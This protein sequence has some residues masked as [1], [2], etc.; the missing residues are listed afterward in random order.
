MV[1]TKETNGRLLGGVH[2]GD[3]L[4][5]GSCGFERVAEEQIV[6]VRQT[7]SAEDDLVHIGPQG[8]VGH[9][10]V[11][12][13]VGVGEERNLLSGDYGVVE[14]DSGDS[15]RDDLRRLAPLVGV[16]RRSADLPFLSFD[17]RASVD[18]LA[19]G[20]EE[21]S[22]ELVAYDERRGSAEEG[23]FGVG[24][25]AFGAGEHLKGHEVA[26]GLDYLGELAVHGRE[27]VVGN[28]PGVE[29]HGRL[30]YGLEMRV[31]SLKCFCCH[32][33]ERSLLSCC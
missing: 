13:L 28:S 9:H 32:V 30:G 25:D 27:L 14:V 15:R 24:G 4:V 19:V 21:A 26:L 31:C 6:V 8:H 18:G 10:L 29:R 20:V 16:Y 2:E 11:V 3:Y 1:F 33:Y 22:R 5:E 12:G 7:H 17:L 23:Y